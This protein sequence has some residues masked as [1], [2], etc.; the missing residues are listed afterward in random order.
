MTRGSKTIASA[1]LHLLPPALPPDG[2]VALTLREVCGL[3]TDEIAR[4]FLTAGP[5][6]RKR[7]VRAK[8]KIRAA[9]NPYEVPSRPT[10]PMG[11]TRSSR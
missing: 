7:I 9:G 3:T 11:S 5:T 2:R 4:A 6:L 10:C 8:G 1:D